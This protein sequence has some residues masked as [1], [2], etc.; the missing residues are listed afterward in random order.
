MNVNRTAPAI[1]TTGYAITFRHTTIEPLPRHC[2]EPKPQGPIPGSSALRFESRS[3]PRHPGDLHRI[4]MAPARRNRTGELLP[5]SRCP[6]V[7]VAIS[8]AR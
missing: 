8:S 6:A 3:L 7:A 1:A 5:C 4:G 2:G